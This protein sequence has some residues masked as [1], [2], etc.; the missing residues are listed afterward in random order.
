MNVEKLRRLQAQVRIGGKGTPRR[1]KKVMHQSAATDDKK[2][3][4]SLKKLSVSTIP[5]IEE[6]NIIKD[7]LTVI[8]FN[9]PK[10]Q[11]SLSANTFAVT[12]HGESKKIVEMLPEI[13]PQLGQETVM[14]LRMFAN[15]MSCGLQKSGTGAGGILEKVAE[16]DDDVPLLVNDFEQVAKLEEASKAKKVVTFESEP[17]KIDNHKTPIL[18]KIET[19]IDASKS[20]ENAKKSNDLKEEKKGKKANKQTTDG[21]AKNKT[22]TVKSENKNQ[23]QAKNEKSNKQEKPSA[24]SAIATTVT[25][26]AAKDMK[27]E[28]EKQKLPLQSKEI[29]NNDTSK[30]DIDAQI[31]REV[32]ADKKQQQ[33]QQIKKADFNKKE[34]IT[35]TPVNESHQQKTSGK[36]EKPCGRVDVSRQKSVKAENEKEIEKKDEKPPNV[37]KNKTPNKSQNKE[38]SE[39][40]QSPPSDKNV[41]QQSAEVIQLGQVEDKLQ[42][43]V[44]V[45]ENKQTADKR[46]EEAA[47]SEQLKKY[48]PT[49]VIPTVAVP[50]ENLEISNESRP[51]S[52]KVDE[53]IK[54]VSVTL[55]A[56]QAQSDVQSPTVQVAD[57][58]K[59]IVMTACAETGDLGKSANV[60]SIKPAEVNEKSLPLVTKDD[61]SAADAVIETLAVGSMPKE[62]ERMQIASETKESIKSDIIL[63]EMEQIENK[64]EMKDIK[65]VPIVDATELKSTTV[66]ETDTREIL[67]EKESVTKKMHHGIAQDDKAHAVISA[68]DGSS[69]STA[70][71]TQ[72][73]SP[74][75]QTTVKKPAGP[76][77]MTAAKKEVGES[78]VEGSRTKPASVKP[79][80]IQTNQAKP[81]QTTTNQKTFKSQ[82]PTK[83]MTSP[84]KT[85]ERPVLSPKP[86]TP[87]KAISPQ[88]KTTVVSP[89]KASPSISPLTS[90]GESE[91]QVKDARK[92]ITGVSGKPE[93]VVK[94]NIPPLDSGSQAIIAS[95]EV[96]TPT[97]A[98]SPAA[99][100][101]KKSTIPSKAN[102]STKTKPTNN[103][104]TVQPS[105]EPMTKSSIKQNS[106]SKTSDD[107]NAKLKA[108]T[109][110]D[111]TK[112]VT[113]TKINDPS[114]KTSEQTPTEK[115]QS[116]KTDA[117][118]KNIKASQEKVVA[119]A[120][121]NVQ[122][123]QIPPHQQ[124]E[125]TAK[126]EI[127]PKVNIEAITKTVNETSKHT[128]PPKGAEDTTKPKVEANEKGTDVSVKPETESLPVKRT[129]PQQTVDAAAAAAKSESTQSS[130]PKMPK[131][132]QPTP[133][134]PAEQTSPQNI[135]DVGG[136]M[137]AAALPESIGI[138]N[139]QV[140]KEVDAIVV[141]ESTQ[142]LAQ[143]ISPKKALDIN[144][145]VTDNVVSFACKPMNE[146]IPPVQQVEEMV[147]PNTEANEPI[148]SRNDV[149]KK[150]QT[151]EPPAEEAPL[152]A[153]KD[154][155]Q[156]AK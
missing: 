109:K 156:L 117:A 18:E 149:E 125:I 38:S 75:K 49:I 22:E 96:A 68:I 55:T 33:Q 11:A 142:L 1:K 74:S 88:P 44:T 2:L 134:P 114:P 145:K 71:V 56:E 119:D 20:F 136:G 89:T 150:D 39:L 122:E 123:Q 41:E 32:V 67:K 19:K 128:T 104:A 66:T 7:D 135:L 58:L 77:T 53:Q 152:N 107:G 45:S 101:Q 25:A 144:A 59:P 29:S 42:T 47:A 146:Q 90:V 155:N 121:G 126:S 36:G 93:V 70:A 116:P 83:I 27:K 130:S 8:H 106:P 4:S 108:T 141:G 82:T 12:G 151:L 10:A 113:P 132:E 30:S 80:S 14:Q 85:N 31:K 118:K 61:M 3:Q 143:Q 46:K 138:A 111:Q 95:D 73:A 16:E 64:T 154:T 23:K 69:K 129:S 72:K 110:Q 91:G 97:K 86:T 43:A 60:S 6:V 99:K 147:K 40:Q 120:S 84:S 92:Q 5:G 103:K 57:N 148:S 54:V 98:S 87:T 24:S 78:K 112:Q 9:N 153:S 76:S 37:E 63:V 140:S 65:Q 51:T 62:A 137:S 79:T 48:E 115:G 127:L 102:Q 131:N 124:K 34:N 15:T 21:A 52:S 28:N 26:T 105:S 50:K 100:A 139:V 17:Q 13:L 133:T 94:P 35:A 81:S